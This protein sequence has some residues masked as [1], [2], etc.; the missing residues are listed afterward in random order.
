MLPP[1]D[2]G[3]ALVFVRDRGVLSTIAFDAPR[4]GEPPPRFAVTS[5]PDA[6]LAVLHYSLRLA[7]MGWSPESV[8]ADATTVDVVPPP[9][10][11]RAFVQAADGALELVTVDALVAQPLFTEARVRPVPSSIC[12]EA[13]G[14]FDASPDD[15]ADVVCRVPCAEPA[16][17]IEP[18]P[19]APL[20]DAPCP[21]GWSP[22]AAR[23]LALQ[24]QGPMGPPFDVA[25]CLPGG[26]PEARCGPGALWLPSAGACLPLWTEC[27][28]SGWPAGLGADA[29]YVRAGALGDGS[30]EHPFGRVGDAVRVARGV[31]HVA[32]GRYDEALTVDVPATIRGVCSGVVLGEVH[33]TSPGVVFEDVA[34][35]GLGGASLVVAAG[36]GLELRDV[37]VAGRVVVEGA[38]TGGRVSIDGDAGGAALVVRGAA[39]LESVDVAAAASAGVH[40][41]GDAARLELVDAVVRGTSTATGAAI[42]GTRGTVVLTHALLERAGAGLSFEGAVTATLTD[43]VVRAMSRPGRVVPAV[44]AR[45]AGTHVFAK[46]LTVVDVDHVGV[47]ADDGAA[48]RLEDVLVANVRGESRREAEALQVVEGSLTLERALLLGFRKAAL[49]LWRAERATV[50]DLVAG[51]GDGDYA[52]LHAYA[53]ALDLER[54]WIEKAEQPAIHVE[55]GVVKVSDVVIRHVR[56]GVLVKKGSVFELRRADVA[57]IWGFGVAVPDDGAVAEEGARATVEDLTITLIESLRPSYCA[58]TPCTS[59]GV[60]VRGRSSAQVERFRVREAAGAGLVRAGDARLTAT[61]G[62]LEANLFGV[63]AGGEPQVRAS[64]RR[65]RITGSTAAPVPSTR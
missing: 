35:E 16:P 6:E 63:D 30:Q 61:D 45:G 64:L 24:D 3:S 46:R 41:E 42:E 15:P 32:P 10:P 56:G 38:L 65:V 9:R 47:Q 49:E 25:R 19:V 52:V 18:H 1:L 21:D 36:G 12:F 2:E 17:P 13:G 4:P 62:V 54:A 58:I 48:L 23:D 28:S 22:V 37:H 39:A 53:S 40:V 33:V 50:R 5:S 31:I 11:Q 20:D 14:C 59:A 7:E 26:S 60:E 34:F 27:P 29:V 44:R 51:G 55:G 43:V 57:G 8:V